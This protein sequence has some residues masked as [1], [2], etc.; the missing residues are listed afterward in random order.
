MLKFAHYLNFPFHI[1][2]VLL[3]GAADKLGGQRQFRFTVLGQEHRSEFSPAIARAPGELERNRR[4]SRSS[5]IHNNNRSQFVHYIPSQFLFPDFVVILWVYVCFDPNLTVREAE[6]QFYK[7]THTVVSVIPMEFHH[8]MFVALVG[9]FQT[10]CTVNR[11]FLVHV[12]H[13]ACYNVLMILNAVH[14]HSYD[15][16]TEHGSKWNETFIKR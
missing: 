7:Y 5:L 9:M 8:E 16:D 11:I 13:F 6:L 4:S 2:A 15:Y 1:L 14:K 3:L 12:N 10:H